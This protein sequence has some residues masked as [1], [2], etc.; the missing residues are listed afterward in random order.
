[1]VVAAQQHPYWPDGTL[2]QQ[3]WG[4]SQA[5]T[6][7][8]P[9]GTATGEY[10]GRFIAQYFNKNDGVDPY[11]QPKPKYVE[12]MNE[13][14]YDLVDATASPEPLDKIFEF[15]NAVADAIRTVEREGIPA[16]DD[17]LIGGYTAAF[18]DFDTDNFAEWRE[19]DQRYIDITG[20][21]MDFISIHLYDF[22]RF[23]NTEQ[24]RKGSNMEATM[25]MLEQYTAMQL[26]EP[27]PMLISEYGA[28]VHSMLNTPWT[29][30]RDGFILESMNSMLMSFL[31][32]PHLIE[33]AIPFVT[34]KAEWGRAD[35]GTPYLHRLMRQQ[36]EAQG[37][38]GDLWVYSELV[39]FYQQWSEVSGQRIVTASED[40]DLLIDAYADGQTLY[41]ILN[42]LE[43]DEVD[44]DM[45]S[46]IDLMPTQVSIKH[47][48]RVEGKPTLE[49]TVVDSLTDTLTIGGQGTAILKLTLAQSVSPDTTA[50]KQKH[51]AST[52]L[53]AISASSSIDF[54]IGLDETPTAGFATLRLGIGHAHGL[55]QTPTIT[56]NGTALT[57]PDD[58]ARGR[59]IS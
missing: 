27:M 33:M 8:E 22:P 40:L 46:L 26:G 20:D 13:P 47:L 55:S 21:N 34:V 39:K 2:T 49:T 38:T 25:D 58:V 52:Y 43:F 18:P 41:V 57:V 7:D 31:Q 44:V 23:Q 11:G 50:Q 59:P 37:E 16:N 4:F 12:V 10:M 32:R 35:N 15:H 48:Y 45:S 3:S 51:Y 28:Q 6:P 5:D 42:N 29:P 14:L 53:Q 9:F 54:A 24:Y 1:M 30:E 36:H 19:R 56:V 17:V